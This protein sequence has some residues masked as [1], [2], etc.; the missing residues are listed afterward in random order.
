MINFIV[1]LFNSVISI[2]YPNIPILISII[3]IIISVISISNSTKLSL[4]EKRE[5]ILNIANSIIYNINGIET[6]DNTK[7]EKKSYY[8]RF[9]FVYNNVKSLEE[10]NSVMS[11]DFNKNINGDNILKFRIII[12]DLK[13][14]STL[15]KNIIKNENIYLPLEEFHDFL[16]IIFETRNTLGILAEI[17]KEENEKDSVGEEKRKKEYENK[18]T[19]K[20]EEIKKFEDKL[21]KRVSIINE[22]KVIEKSIKNYL[23]IFTMK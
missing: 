14:K 10:L 11:M 4:Y 17:D 15:S 5:N 13:Y 3:A 19:A 7:T 21:Y 6:K 9:M 1:D 23:E 8:I 12:N 16:K 20:L 18:K 2:I 22:E